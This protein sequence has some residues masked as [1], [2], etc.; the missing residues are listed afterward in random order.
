MRL[1]R[2]IGLAASAQG[3]KARI[4]VVAVEVTSTLLRTELEFLDEELE[5]GG[6]RPNIAATIFSD[7]ASAMI[8]GNGPLEEDGKCCHILFW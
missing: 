7:A 5:N 4:L 6:N 3:R 8:I 2:N 1:A